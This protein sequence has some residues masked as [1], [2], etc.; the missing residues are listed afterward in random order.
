MR[1]VFAV[2]RFRNKLTLFVS[3]INSTNEPNGG[4]QVTVDEVVDSVIYISKDPEP[5]PSDIDYLVHSVK[6]VCSDST[7]TYLVML[8]ETH[9]GA[10]SLDRKNFIAIMGGTNSFVIWYCL[11]RHHLHLSSLRPL[12]FY[13]YDTLT[14]Y[15]SADYYFVKD[16]TTIG[17]TIGTANDCKILDRDHFYG[18][19][20]V[21]DD[22][23]FFSQDECDTV[24][25]DSLISGFVDENTVYLFAKDNTVYTFSAKVFQKSKPSAK[26]IKA[27]K[28]NAW[29]GPGDEPPPSKS[30]GESK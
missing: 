15:G 8:N 2:G 28:K 23:V 19:I 24:F 6:F 10:L 17:A 11:G 7:G 30:K 29:K 22:Q 27:S 21:K 12:H 13:Q 20:C 1:G 5:L 9:S 18:F 14:Q 4:Y 26:L 3:G 16:N 25:T